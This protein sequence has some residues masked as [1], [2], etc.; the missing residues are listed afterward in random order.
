MALALKAASLLQHVIDECKRD[1][2]TIELRPRKWLL[3]NG[4]RVLGFFQEPIANSS[5]NGF[6]RVAWSNPPT[7]YQVRTLAHEFVHYL[8]WMHGT[9]NSTCYCRREES[10]QEQSL[11][12]LGKHNI[13]LSTDA[14][15]RDARYSLLFTRNC[16]H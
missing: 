12:I 4:V 13:S 15:A 8:Q 14:L 9:I 7:E 2:I 3:S 6:I 11:K 1:N 10:A 5:R 16:N